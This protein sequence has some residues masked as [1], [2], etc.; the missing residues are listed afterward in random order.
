MYLKVIH[1]FIKI[2]NI[3]KK[4]PYFIQILHLVSTNFG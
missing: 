4:V 3:D 2:K 1:K